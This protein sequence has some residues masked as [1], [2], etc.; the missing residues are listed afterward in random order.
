VNDFP[1]NHR[2]GQEYSCA[3]LP[4][5]FQPIAAGIALFMMGTASDLRAE[6]LPAWLTDASLTTKVGYDTDVFGTEY[7]PAEH[8]DIANVSSVVWGVSPSLSANLRPL[9]PASPWL[10]TFVLS[11][12]GDYSIYEDAANQTNERHNFLLQLKGQ[13]DDWSY[14]VDNSFIDVDGSRESPIYSTLNTWGIAIPRERLDQTQE[15]NTSWLRYDQPQWFARLTESALYYDLL[16][17][18]HDPIGAY[19]GYVNFI[20]RSDSNVGADFGY[21]LLPAFSLL[22]GWRLGQQSQE[23]FS[24]GGVHN[25]STYNRLLFGFEGQLTPWL[26]LQALAGPDWRRYSDT[27]HLGVTGDRHTWQYSE[28][29]LSATLS[30]ADTL[31]ASEKIWHWVSQN[32]TSSYQE[33]DYAADYKHAFSSDL[34]AGAGIKV[35]GGRFDAPVVRNDWYT[36]YPVYV[37]YRLSHLFTLRADYFYG[38][39]DS[40]FSAAVSPGQQFQDHLTTL[41]LAAHF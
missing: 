36:T 17:H 20:N 1:S 27:A 26:K 24:W 2:E 32:G 12:R 19:V 25:D 37:S 14:S 40:H 31:T 9:L 33:T 16:D 8:P 35:I 5:R 13:S 28:A 39:G 30:P 18:R 34:S 29:S 4:R 15:R 7:S 3:G 41:S 21:K 11:Y 23:E 10:S 38:V 6:D 22:A